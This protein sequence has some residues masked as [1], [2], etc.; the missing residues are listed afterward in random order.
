MVGGGDIHSVREN[1]KQ[2]EAEKWAEAVDRPE[3]CTDKVSP[4]DQPDEAENYP[5]AGKF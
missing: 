5:E 4:L 2:P 1:S 3:F